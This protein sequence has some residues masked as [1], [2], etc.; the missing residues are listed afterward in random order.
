MGDRRTSVAGKNVRAIGQTD[1]LRVMSFN[2]RVA[3]ADDGENSW[4]NRRELLFG[5]IETFM[6]DLLG[7]QEVQPASEQEL[8][9]RLRGY[10]MITACEADR[11]NPSPLMVRRNRFDIERSGFFWL[12]PKPEQWESIGWD[13]MFPRIVTWVQLR[14]KTADA[15]P[16]FYFNTHWDH[17]GNLARFQSALLMRKRIAQIAGDA[18]V[19]VTGDFNC[20]DETEP[21]ATLLS[22]SQPPRLFDSYRELHPQRSADDFTFH[23][24]TGKVYNDKCLRI[25]WIL[26]SDALRTSG[27]QIVRTSEQGRYP[28]DHFPVTAVFEHAR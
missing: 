26:H 1:E 20:S 24:F 4:P 16:V 2:I 9:R 7:L 25:D 12:S 27:S 8:T 10:E 15:A 11:H 17:R 23:A 14:D 21:Y 5:T 6:P 13:A 22:H 28:S 18:P 3:S 19:I